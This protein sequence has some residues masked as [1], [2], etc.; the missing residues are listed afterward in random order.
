MI[1]PVGRRILNFALSQFF[2]QVL[3]KGAIS[4]E[5]GPLIVV[6]NH[7]NMALDPFLISHVYNRELFF[8]A[9][10]T[11]FAGPF[12]SKFLKACHLI[13]VYRRQDNPADMGR[14]EDTFRAAVEVLHSGKGVALFPEGMSL[15]ER[16]L[17]T[18]K[19]GA[20]RIAFQA[21]AARDF[22]LGLKIQ[23]V[24]I[25]YSDLDLFQG[26]VTM[27]IGEP[28]DI[29]AFRERY[30]RDAVATVKSVTDV[31]EDALRALVVEVANSQHDQLVEK[32]SKVY[33]SRDG[34]SDDYRR[35]KTIAANIDQ[36]GGGV[37]AAAGLIKRIDDYLV[38]NSVFGLEG[39]ENFE[40]RYGGRA[41]WVFTP[42]L[43][44]AALLNFLPFRLTGPLA[45]RI[46]RH[47]ADR[48]TYKLAVG[49]ALFGAWYIFLSILCASWTGSV[50]LGFLS[51]LLLLGA[52]YCSN[53]YRQHL[54]ILLLSLFWPGTK[55]PVDVVKL[56]RDDL[57]LEL[58][59]LRVV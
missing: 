11:L 28:I 22:K 10:S 4:V 12:I 24:G 23:P 50:L 46:S 36:L 3:V 25:T 38:L 51:F 6:A 55:N 19:T 16:R 30:E 44:L 58:E 17:Q 7:P 33:E 9:K 31:V 49:T 20:A 43:T 42:L 53:R 35:L 48:G 29:G 26:S 56:V 45:Q 32:I 40:Q 1:Y 8:L 15:G 13:P 2:S 34:R 21:E 37:E 59:R 18:L 5:T 54:R 41:T 52:G 27:Y 47:P 14:N 39:N 57:I